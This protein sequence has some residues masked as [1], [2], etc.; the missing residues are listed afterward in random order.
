MDHSSRH[1]ASESAKQQGALKK[2]G[3]GSRL[4]S[5]FGLAKGHHQPPDTQ[6]FL[7][8]PPPLPAGDP[9]RGALVLIN[10]YNYAEAG[11]ALPENPWQLA[12]Q[13][14]DLA[15]IEAMYGFIWL[16]DLASHGGR[17]A[18][19]KARQLVEHWIDHL[20]APG[21][22]KPADVRFRDDIIAE[23]LSRLLRRSLFLFSHDPP[24]SFRA[25]ILGALSLESAH[26]IRS[27]IRNHAQGASHKQ[28]T[29]LSSFHEVRALI[30][31]VLA[32]LSLEGHEEALPDLMELLDTRLGKLVLA[33]GMIANRSPFAQIRL[34]IALCGLK[35]AF[36]HAGSP[37]PASIEK[38]M[39]RMA[40][41]ARMLRH[42]DGGLAQ[43]HTSREGNTALIDT[44]IAGSGSK[45]PRPTIL[46]DG[47]FARM[48][49]R[50]LLV[51]ADGGGPPSSENLGSY[52]SSPLA[53]EVSHGP[54]RII[55]NCGTMRLDHP[56]WQ[57]VSRSSAA[58]S[59]VVLDDT[60]ALDP[61]NPP[62]HFNSTMKQRI[63]DGAV[64]LTLSHN[65]Y[66]PL[67]GAEFVKR[68][69]YMPPNGQELLGEEQIAPTA[70]SR[71]FVIRF[72]LHPSVEVTLIGDP[73]MPLLRLP[74]GMNWWFRADGV[75]INLMESVYLGMDRPT[76]P[77]RQ[78]VLTG[79][80]S[81]E[82]THISWMLEAAAPAE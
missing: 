11:Q 26:L 47:G 73:A 48:Q 63:V 71:P 32:S 69:L 21:G 36:D 78:I 80:T 50:D 31:A 49:A 81:Y 40:A 57:R 70:D 51:I 76:V 44:A 18:A 34:L 2:G 45:E 54:E 29:N 74:S 33:D 22:F 46:P 35:Q 82:T 16:D 13:E 19:L 64:W 53:I 14:S 39:H 67:Y 30:G 8:I 1:S 28:G 66:Q 38:A 6:R 42:G 4:L 58:H 27:C 41:A 9:K 37:F 52:H 43:F 60:S 24:E 72:H 79:A 56:E 68:K 65:G 3:L 15:W 17:V 59:T 55:V 20:K 61:D 12:G 77:T 7:T 5:A 62:A 10:R 25:R 23:R 75:S